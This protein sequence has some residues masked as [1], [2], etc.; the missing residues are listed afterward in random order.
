MTMH[1][2]HPALTTS[3]RQRTKR[4]FQSAEQARLHRELNSDWQN[5]QQRWGVEKEA[6]RQKR[7]MNSGVYQAPRA[8]YRGAD[9]PRIPSLDIAVTGALGTR[10]IMDPMSW[11]GESP[12]VIAATQAK[13]QR[14]MP[15]YNKG[16]VQY[17]TDGED[18]TTVG[19]KSRRL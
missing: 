2:A 9:A 18:L 7:A 19:S 13:A 16:P 12:E 10:S 1:L 14:L 8:N 17:L 5:L 15:L 4:K 3:G 11:R 6:Q